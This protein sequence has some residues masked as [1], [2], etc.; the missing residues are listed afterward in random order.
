MPSHVLTVVCPSRRGIVA[1][2]AGFLA[3]QG[4]NII[5]SSQFD[6]LDTGRFFMRVTFVSELGNSL[7]T[8]DAAFGAVAAAGEMTYAFHDGARRMQVLLM[9]SR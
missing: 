5:D 2:V 3:D 8:L 4:C 1:A 9:V 7:E 6:D